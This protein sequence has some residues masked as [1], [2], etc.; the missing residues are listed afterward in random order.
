M[1]TRTQITHYDDLDGSVDGIRTVQ[2]ALDG[3]QVEIDL[4][5]ANYETLTKVLDP[6]LSAGRKTTT[7]RSRRTQTTRS[8]PAATDTQSIREWAKAS[9]MKVSD[10]GRVSAEIQAAYEAAH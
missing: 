5:E 1:G 7:T 10:R 9:A 2:L 6:Y 3:Q 8:K 4:S